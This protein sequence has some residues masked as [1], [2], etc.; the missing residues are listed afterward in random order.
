M[1]TGS[2][3]AKMLIPFDFDCTTI[4]PL[5]VFRR[6]NFVADFIVFWSKF[7]R[8]MTN[9]VSEPHFSKV[10]GDVGPLRMLVGKPMST[11]LFALI[12]LFR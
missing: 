2:F 12:Q 3:P 1:E 10:R 8:K 5:E 9:L 7:L 6:R 4:L 11:F